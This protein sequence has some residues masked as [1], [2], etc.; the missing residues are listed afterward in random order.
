MGNWVRFLILPVSMSPEQNLR[1]V[2]L[3]SR[4]VSLPDFMLAS[5]R[6]GGGRAQRA[7]GSEMGLSFVLKVGVAP[8]TK[9]NTSGGF[10]PTSFELKKPRRHPRDL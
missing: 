1:F 10:E 9:A 7:H 2:I 5:E 3:T 8:S 4:V 6:E